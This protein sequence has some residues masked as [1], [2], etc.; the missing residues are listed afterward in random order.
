MAEMMV[1]GLVLFWA[2]LSA[3]RWADCL[4]YLRDFEVAVSMAAGR[5]VLMDEQLVEKKECVL[6]YMT[7]GWWASMMETTTVVC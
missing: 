7:D 3:A 2:E 1:D 6:V 5:A 4:D